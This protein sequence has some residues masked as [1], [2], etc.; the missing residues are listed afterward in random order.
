M[1]KERKN[2]RD[3]GERGSRS[4]ND[5]VSRSWSSRTDTY[6][7]YLPFFFRKPRGAVPTLLWR[8]GKREERDT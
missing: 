1:R 4:E 6:N 7:F 3:E 2:L 8:V 5:V